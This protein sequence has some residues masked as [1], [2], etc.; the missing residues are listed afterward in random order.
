MSVDISLVRR[1]DLIMRAVDAV[2]FPHYDRVTLQV[3]PTFSYFCYF[4]NWC[5]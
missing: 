2:A 1:Q 5:Y 3:I 4:C